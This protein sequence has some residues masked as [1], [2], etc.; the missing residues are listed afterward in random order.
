[1][2]GTPAG[3]AAERVQQAS[4]AD[5]VRHAYDM[6]VKARHTR[7]G[8][9]Q[10]AGTAVG[11]DLLDEI[12]TTGL[13]QYGG[14]VVEEWL[15]Q[16]SGRRAVWAYR[17]MMDNSP[18]VG[19]VL[20]AIEWLARGVEWRVEEGA[21]ES[22]AEFVE[23]C[24]HDMSHT[25]QDFVSEALSMLPYGWAWH[26]TVYKRRQGYQP[27]R[28][29]T[30]AQVMSG[31]VGGSYLTGAQASTQE[32]DNLASS[33][34]DDGRV[35]WR[36]IP[37]RAQETLFN[38]VFD[39]Y[40][41]IQAMHQ[42]DW[43]GGNHFV[44]ISKSLLFR[45]RARRNNPE[46]YS[47]LRTAYTSYY[48]LKNIQNIEGTGI[49]RDLAGIPKLTPPDD[50]D[51]WAP[52]N[53][54]LL[55]KAQDMV[56][57][58][59]RDD[60]E[61]IVL[62]A[63]WEF[64]LVSSGGSR[65]IDT[66]AVIRRYEQRIA[67]SMLADF[68]LLGQDA[69]GSYAMVDVKADLFGLALDG[70][71]D[72]ICEPINRYAIPRLLRLNGMDTSDPPRL[73]HG[74]AGRINLEKVGN[75]FNWLAMA[76]APIPWSQE[77]LET[78]FAEAGLPTNF[79][80]QNPPD[81]DH[82]KEEE[83]I[84]PPVAPPQPGAPMPP[85]PDPAAPAPVV[86]DGTAQTNAQPPK[87]LAK[88]EQHRGAMVAL[89]PR[90]DTAD[91][92]SVDGGEAADQ[93]HVTLAHLGRASD[94]A[95]PDRLRNTV[96]QWAA[97]TPPLEGH[98]SGA[99]V[100]LH[101]P[102]APVAY[103]TPDLPD[104][105]AHRQR[106]VERLQR[107]GTPPSTTHGFMPHIT[108]A[109]G[110][111]DLP[112]VKPQPVTF[113]HASLVI[114]GERHDFPLAGLRKAA[115]A[116]CPNCGTD[117]LVGGGCP[118]CG[119]PIVK[120]ARPKGKPVNVTPALRER[121]GELAPHLDQSIHQV[122]ANLGQEAA[123]VYLGLVGQQQTSRMRK[124]ATRRHDDQKM[125]QAVV[126]NVGVDRYV[127]QQVGGM[128]ARHTQ[129][130]LKD[131]TQTLS[132]EL[133]LQ[134]NVPDP[135]ARQIIAAGGR[136]VGLLDVNKQAKKAIFS[137]LAEGRANGDGP[138]VIAK[139]IEQSVPAGRFTN[140]GSQYRSQL[141]SRTETLNAQRQS[142]LAAYKASP[143][144]TGCEVRDGLLPDS[145]AECEGRDGDIVSFDAASDLANDEHP[146]GTLSFNPIVVQPGELDEE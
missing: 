71:L 114:A 20:F 18:I 120:A 44:P 87:Q 54:E 119:D 45:S 14:F 95:D 123:R 26:E 17:E 77:L 63:G 34:Y 29:F 51:I 4:N 58:I 113:D 30:P 41:G 96:A 38:W 132:T 76:G 106:L 61:G 25:W 28:P 75:F 39:G 80:E 57:S 74:S 104:L 48:Y 116:E 22:Q 36:K 79:E 27:D 59:R 103:A 105:P 33:E 130:V 144:I 86:D 67:T 94:I 84:E 124:A 102:D 7:R 127:T 126:N 89:Y 53:A 85:V 139:R 134:V 93:L 66:D 49:E 100:F 110:S 115:S 92:L 52:A 78:L 108:L 129:R 83:E 128:L 82:L 121:I 19:A 6:V 11:Q 65:Q 1:M 40:S 142:A 50:V 109:Y 133:G 145:D 47:M 88:A 91:G 70:I 46:G 118:N 9:L 13:R 140:A 98:I 32:D 117:L 101:G 56:Q 8:S 68:I 2:R 90:A 137:A 42:I 125:A 43:H 55:A 21:D 16:L 72:L 37:I 138:G 146:L 122:L 141:I 31:G 23:Q 111:S 73:A 5:Q 143:F 12:G 99:G 131:T 81:L 112:P 64:E 60:H 107:N 10:K 136:R 15:N 3:R 62:P 35:G 69:V 97:N 24:M 135:V